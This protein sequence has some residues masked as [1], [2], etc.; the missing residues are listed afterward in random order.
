MGTEKHS[1]ASRKR[2]ADVPKEKR[3][4]RMSKVSKAGWDA[5]DSKARRR[6]ALKGIRTKRKNLEN[7]K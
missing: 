3:K 6:R 2:W 1:D 7:N 5:L 4:K